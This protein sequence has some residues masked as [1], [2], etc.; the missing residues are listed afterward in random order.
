[1]TASITIN[2]A[3]GVAASNTVDVMLT[4]CTVSAGLNSGV[5]VAMASALTNVTVTSTQ[6]AVATALNA[7]FNGSVTIAIGWTSGQQPEVTLN[8]L[9]NNSGP[10]TVTWPTASGP[11][12]QI[13]T[14]G[15]PM[16]LAGI[17]D[18]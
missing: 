10:A 14:P 9:L 7:Q 12:T 6:V 13:L 11:Q 15:D 1:M 18:S 3:N 2:F 16:A 8:N 4:N 17:V 5:T